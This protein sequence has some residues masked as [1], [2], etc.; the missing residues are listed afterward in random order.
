MMEKA[1]NNIRFHYKYRDAANYKQYGFVIFSNPAQVSTEIIM[2]K[3]KIELIDHEYFIPQ[4]CNI[5][6]IYRFPFD[7]EFDH[8]WYEVDYLEETNETVTDERTI[9]MFIKDCANGNLYSK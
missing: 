2:E 7:L 4:R 1:S 8:G 3:L 9:E 5:P 6:L